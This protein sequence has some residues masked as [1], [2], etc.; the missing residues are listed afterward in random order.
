MR[1]YMDRGGG[2]QTT[3]EIKNFFP[4]SDAQRTNCARGQ[5]SLKQGGDT[6]REES[7]KRGK[8]EGEKARRGAAPKRRDM[9]TNR[10]IK[11]HGRDGE[12]GK[13]VIKEQGERAPEAF[14]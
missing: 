13:A 4:P 7:T 2:A 3:Q 14:T 5:T 6:I 1:T 9:G 10:K 8:G 12:E 11:G